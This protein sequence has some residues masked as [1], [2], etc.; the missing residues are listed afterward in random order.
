MSLPYTPRS[1]RDPE[2]LK[3]RDDQLQELRLGFNGGGSFMITG[4]KRVGKTSLVNVFLRSL[5]LRKDTLALYIPIGELSA[6]SG[7]DLGRFGH[8]LI[9]RTLEGYADI[10]GEEAGVEL[11]LLE[12]FRASFN[13][14]LARCLRQF[15]RIHPEVRLVFALDD[16]DELPTTL[17]TG[18]VGRTLFLSL[19]SQINNGLSFFFIGSERLPTIIKEQ[20]Q[21]LNQVKSLKV[22]YLDQQAL[23]ALVREPVQGD[24]EYTDDAITMIETWSARNPYFATLICSAIW[25]RAIERRDYWITEHDVLD[26]I[27]QFV[28]RSSRNSYEHFWSDSPLASEDARHAYETRS[29]YLLLTLSKRQPNPLGYANR[30]EIV[31]MSAMLD[32]EEAGLHLQDLINYNVVEAHPQNTELVRIRV[33]LFTLWLT[34][35]GATELEQ[36]ELMKQKRRAGLTRQEELAASE[37]VAVTE[38]LS[39]R[40][41]H[42]SADEVRVWA[43]QFGSLDEQRLILQLLHRLRDQ[44]LYDQERLMFAV[45]QLHKIVRQKA[46]ERKFE[47]QLSNTS[48]QPQNI[49]VTHADKIGESGSALVRFY[50]NQ[51]KMLERLCGSPEKVFAAIGKN[52]SSKSVVVC[53]DDLIGSGQSA[54]AQI[55]DLMPRLMHYVAA[56][57]KYLLYPAIETNYQGT[58]GIAFSLTSPTLNPS[59]GYVVRKSGQE[60]FSDIHITALGSG[61][62]IGFTCALGFPQ[63][64]RW[65]DYSAAALDP[66]GQDIWMAAEDIV[67]QVATQVVPGVGTFHTNWGTRVWDVNGN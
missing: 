52:V 49:Y 15:S 22:D 61:P 21:R 66:N 30:R 9:R 28:K 63:E 34:S 40:G 65:G 53:V 2:K 1:I 47:I 4:Q 11:P 60:G 48:R 3:G 56:A 29:S 42:I 23:V 31:D 26:T 36:D 7:D 39:Y 12:E 55:N 20:A 37:V 45:G 51:N 6:A 14:P 16:F 41:R 46:Q 64:C 32:K 62:D 58:T 35:S 13:E 17:F 50:R 25:Q 18:S 59:T 67:P 5:S 43:S 27:N 57:G 8:E 24:L 38:G 33:P 19:R 54:A 10:F 44:G